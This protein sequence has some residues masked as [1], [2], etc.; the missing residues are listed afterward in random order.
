MRSRFP[1]VASVSGGMRIPFGRRAF[2]TL[3]CNAVICGSISHAAAGPAPAPA[4]ARIERAPVE[5]SSL[6]SIGFAREAR[7]LEIEF[8]SG[9]IY[10]YLGVPLAVFDGL[11][12]AESKGRYF[13]QSIRGKYEFQRVEAAAK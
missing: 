12:K 8:R 9:A 10:R 5:S 7:V 3:L 13:A 4:A 6:V 11:K 2:C 1:G